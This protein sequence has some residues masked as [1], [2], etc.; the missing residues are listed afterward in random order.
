MPLRTRGVS[1]ATKRRPAGAGT[2]RQL[3]S[4]RWQARFRGPDGVMRPA[5]V[6]FDTKL[7]AGAWLNGQAQDVERGTWAPAEGG[8]ATST[9]TLKDYSATWLASRDLKPRTRLLYRNLLDAVILPDLGDARLDRIS[10]TTVRNWYATLDES[11]PT[12]RAHAYSLLRAIYT[13]AVSDDLVPTNPCRIRGAGKAKKAHT[14]RVASLAELEVIVEALPVRYRPMVLLAA[15][16]SL[17]FGELAELRRGDVDLGQRDGQCPHCWRPLTE[18]GAQTCPRPHS[19]ARHGTIRVERAVTTRDG[20]VFVGDPKSDAGK[21]TVAIP[22]HL[23]PVLEEHLRAHVDEGADALLFPAV[24]G[25]HL[26]PTTFHT[27]WSKAREKAKRPDL[28]FHDLRHTGAT[29]AA[30]TGATLA[31]LMTRLG[32]STPQAA[33]VYQH[34]AADRDRA[35]AEALSG[36]ADAKVVP[37]RAVRRG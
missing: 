22:P 27:P 31:E 9:T 33:M 13:T 16:C 17:R 11:T 36:F 37:L 5:P 20:Q 8:L 7:D 34:A 29:L 4:G 3:P 26:A 25:G 18:P 6:T 2:T 1:M 32:H 35:I 30:A 24:R 28:R 10:P 15:W 12:R 19:G 14:T 23:V 21:R